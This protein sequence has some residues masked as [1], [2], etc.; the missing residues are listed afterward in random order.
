MWTNK[1]LYIV[2][3]N[4]G[5]LWSRKNPEICYISTVII[6]KHSRPEINNSANS[7]KITSSSAMR[8]VTAQPGARGRFMSG[9][10]RWYGCHSVLKNSQW[11]SMRVTCGVM[12]DHSSLCRALHMEAL[13]HDPLNSHKHDAQHLWKTV[14]PLRCTLWARRRAKDRRCAVSTYGDKHREERHVLHIRRG[15]RTKHLP[16]PTASER[17]RGGRYLQSQGHRRKWSRRWR[18]VNTSDWMQ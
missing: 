13:I 5:S 12:S 18:E 11:K 17:A 9:A 10:M 4:K 15:R 2:T 7:M 1:Y 8:S 14:A 3:T 16:A 6:S